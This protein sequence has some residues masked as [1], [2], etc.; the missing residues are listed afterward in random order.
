MIEIRKSNDRGLADHGWLQS[1]HSF[2]FAGYFDPQHVEFGALRVINE[3]RV[4]PGGGF[5]T[6]PH[7][8]MEIISYVLAGE[9][10]HRDSMGNGSVIVP[11]DVQRMSAGT[12][13]LHSEMNPS[14]TT[15]VH[16]LQ[17]WIQPDQLGVAPGYEQKHFTDEEKRGRLRLIVSGDGAEGSVRIHQDARLYAGLF[18]GEEG[19]TLQ[20]AAGR[21]IYVHLVRGELTANDTVL[22]GGDALK[23]T[24]VTTLTLRAGRDAEVLV[25]D[26]PAERH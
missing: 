3:D 9:L 21:R 26:L 8:D 2:S 22:T 20:V 25:F 12:G 11:G 23:L 1:R 6:H 7:R 5:G 15:P 18:D 14:P 10:G 13:V 17:I 24:D 16:F 19:A 4:A